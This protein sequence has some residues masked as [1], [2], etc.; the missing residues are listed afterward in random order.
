MANDKETKI[1]DVSP[2]VAEQVL[3]ALVR[4][5]NGVKLPDRLDGQ[6]F[7]RE[8]IAVQAVR[9]PEIPYPIFVCT[10]RDLQVQKEIEIQ[11]GAQGE[12]SVA[13]PFLNKWNKYQGP[14]GTVEYLSVGF[15]DG[16]V[17]NAQEFLTPHS[18]SGAE[19]GI[20]YPDLPHESGYHHPWH[21]STIVPSENVKALV[22]MTGVRRISNL[23]VG[24]GVFTQPI[25]K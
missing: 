24:I 22:V 20:A 17:Y 25:L 14:G 11:R 19:L 5:W 13:F 21:M 16:S 2:A 4:P 10:P 3:D 23:T 9:V 6:P 1:G 7:R 15:R 8:D 18:T 12:I